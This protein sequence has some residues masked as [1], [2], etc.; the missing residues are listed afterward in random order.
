VSNQCAQSIKIKKENKKDLFKIEAF[1]LFDVFWKAYPKKQAKQTAIKAWNKIDFSNGTLELILSSI[2]KQKIYKE[3]LKRSGEFCPEWPMPST[4][5]NGHRWEDEVE[6][7][8]DKIPDNY[9]T[10]VNI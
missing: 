9:F 7:P 5:L 6:P 4:W 10:K 8:A 1:E 3:Q 2:E